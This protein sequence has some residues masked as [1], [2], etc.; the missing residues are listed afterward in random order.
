MCPATGSGSFG[1][2]VKLCPVIALRPAL[3]GKASGNWQAA[4]AHNNLGTL[5]KEQGDLE[6]AVQCYQQA[7]LT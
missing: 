7:V 1:S 2:L 5:Y 4:E 3:S 6:K